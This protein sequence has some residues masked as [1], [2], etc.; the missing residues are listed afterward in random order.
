[1]LT[2]KQMD[3]RVT[4]NSVKQGLVIQ[5]TTVIDFQK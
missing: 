2:E 3:N 1:M 4:G 5:D